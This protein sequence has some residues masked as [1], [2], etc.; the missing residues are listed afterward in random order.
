MAVRPHFK[1]VGSMVQADWG[2]EKE[3]LRRLCSVGQVLTSHKTIMFSSRRV[4]PGSKLIHKTL[5]LPRLM[6]GA[7]HAFHNLNPNL[8][9]K[10]C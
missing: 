7:A 6:Y 3:L 2:Q 5:V 10:L 1:R 8:N 9:E 4:G